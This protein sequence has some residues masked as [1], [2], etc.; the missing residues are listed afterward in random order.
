[1]SQ[2]LPLAGRETVSPRHTPTRGQSCCEFDGETSAPRCH[3]SFEPSPG[4][5]LED[6]GGGSLREIGLKRLGLVPKAQSPGA[7]QPFRLGAETLSSLEVSGQMPWPGRARPRLGL[8]VGHT[9]PIGDGGLLGE[10]GSQKPI[11]AGFILPPSYG[12]Q[13]S[14]AKKP[15]RVARTWTWRPLREQTRHSFRAGWIWASC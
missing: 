6:E 1:M 15:T 10:G 9:H 3:F 8:C 2:A 7:A 4:A 11:G 14:E 13:G 5:L 12:R